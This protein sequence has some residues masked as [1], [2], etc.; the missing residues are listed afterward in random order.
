MRVRIPYRALEHIQPR[1]RAPAAV[2]IV[3]YRSAY[4][5]EDLRAIAE[6]RLPRIADIALARAAR[7]ANVPFALSTA[8]FVPMERVRT[9]KSTLYEV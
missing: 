3:N 1:E 9:G 5:M 2:H 8:S 4:N 7:R 6:R